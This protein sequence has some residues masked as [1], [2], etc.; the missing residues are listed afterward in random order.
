MTY[1]I[2]TFHVGQPVIWTDPDGRFWRAV[3][4]EVG[5]DRVRSQIASGASRGFWLWRDQWQCGCM[6][7]TPVPCPPNVTESPTVPD[8]ASDTP[9]GGMV[10]K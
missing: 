10:L 5:H 4:T 3:V 7:M 1:P 2:G 6:T 8:W 9:L